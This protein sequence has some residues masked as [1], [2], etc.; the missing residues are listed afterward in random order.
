MSVRATTALRRYQNPVYQGYFADP[1]VLP[2]QGRYLAYG[3]GSI[4][5]GRV[6]EVL[7]SADLVAW[8][9]V[10]GAL[11]AIDPALGT[12]CWAPEVVEADGRF[13][14]Y[15]SVGFD[16]VGHQL[17]VA[18]ADS[19]YGPFVDQGRNL[20]PAERFAID[21]HPFRDVDGTWYL[22]YAR[23]V[24]EGDRVGTHLA[25]DVLTSMTTLSGN[26][27]TVLAPTADWQ[28][29]QRGRVMYGATHDWHTL[30]GPTVRRYRGRYYC[31]Y[32][33]GSWLDESYAV[34]WAVAAGPLG[35]WQEPPSGTARL[36]S[37]VPGRVRGPGH[38]SLLTTYGGSDLLVYHA[39]DAAGERRQM[40]LDP[41]EWTA[42]GPSTPGPSWTEQ[43]LP[44]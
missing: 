21:P 43:P 22:Y 11:E 3:T 34:S 30:E 15:Y 31:I 4:I 42:E 9:R 37:T 10:G 5:D 25:V 40:W 1:Y 17:R 36:L 14:M 35:P 41:L 27:R 38:N 28:I 32:S 44:R 18:A 2:F 24:L 8:T 7:E 19:P 6:F 13:W 12:D 23:D 26:T 33:G 29:Y 16:D 39:W 20:A